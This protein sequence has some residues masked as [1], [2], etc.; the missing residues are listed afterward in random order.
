MKILAVSQ[1]YYPEGVSFTAM[2]EGLVKKGHE[3]LVVTGQP[4]LGLNRIQEGYENVFDEVINGVRVHRCKLIPK[5]AQKPFSRYQNYLSFWHS[6]KKYL[7]NLKEDFDIV[8]SEVMSPIISV[9]GGNIYARKHHVPH[10]HLCYDLWP[11]SVVVTGATRKGSLLYKVLYFW[12]KRIYKG[13]DKILISSP[14]FEGYFREELK[15]NTPIVYDPQ[16]ALLGEDD[17][18][19]M[20]YEKP[21][22][23]VYAGNVGVLQLV[24]NLT[25]AMEYVQTKGVALHII[26]QGAKLETVKSIIRENHLE[27]SV[28]VYGP[29]ARSI[30]QSYFRSSTAL[31][32][33]LHNKGFV[34][35]TIPNKLVSSL[36]YGKPILAVIGGDG[37][38]VL[39]EAGSA[40]FSASESPKDIASAIDA[41][42]ALSEEER[43][44]KGKLGRD[45]YD[46]NFATAKIVDQ[47]EEELLSSLPR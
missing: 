37:E 47:I 39:K 38:K 40:V 14:S 25:L 7:R 31:V 9:S 21:F 36:Y 22:N 17:L 1:H 27:D 45:Y 46:K 34:G 15:L 33:S 2:C 8:Y 13:F 23:L 4:N 32:V 42:L 18:P 12:S 29:K 30:T 26:G 5:N 35:A 19:P 44:A 41:L 3:V 24:E 20:K 28:Y 10:V 6:S 11:D 16:P 43:E